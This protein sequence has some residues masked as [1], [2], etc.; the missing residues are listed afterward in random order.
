MINF[1]AE[2]S[3]NTAKYVQVRS[4]NINFIKKIGKGVAAPPRDDYNACRII[5]KV[6]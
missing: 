3:G 6:F 4:L 2:V 5:S 1:K